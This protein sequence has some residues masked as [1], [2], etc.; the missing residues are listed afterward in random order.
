M[1][2]QIA[3]LTG[4]DDG[5]MI[6]VPLA[7]GSTTTLQEV[8][9]AV[10]TFEALSAN[11]D[12]RPL[13]SGSGKQ[14]L[15]GG[16]AVGITLEMLNKS[17]IEFDARPGPAV[18]SCLVSGGNL[19]ATLT[20]NGAATGASDPV[21][22]LDSTATFATNGIQ[23][24]A[25]IRNVSDGSV[26]TVVSVDSE[27]QVTTSALTGGGNTWESSD[28]WEIDSEHPFSPTANTHVAFAQDT[29]ASTI[30][31]GGLIVDPSSVAEITDAVWDEPVA[32]HATAGTTG[33]KLDDLS[34]ASVDAIVDGVWDEP[35]G[36]HVVAGTTGKKLVDLPTAAQVAAAVW[37]TTHNGRAASDIMSD[38]L[39]MASG[40]ITEA[41]SG[42]FSFYERDNTTVRYTLTIAGSNR[43]RS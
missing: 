31:V 30:E 2:L 26:G 6:T 27:T 3:R 22:L 1:T 23:T 7:D 43:T 35:V 38:L 33:K 14:S 5:T 20:W 17:T 16:R 42:T 10:R 32:D 34:V 8:Y 29:A 11:M 41:P 24:G 13:C 39:S 18:I 40:K 21:V 28:T 36:S 12:M 15:G 25:V 37:S 19:V 9:D 4:N